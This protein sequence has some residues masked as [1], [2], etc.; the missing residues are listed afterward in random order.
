MSGLENQC[1]KCQSRK[2]Q[3]ELK[4]CG[5]CKS[6]LYCNAECQ[7]RDWPAHK[8]FCKAVTNNWHDKYRG[9]QDGSTHQGDLELITWSL[10]DD[11][12][13]ELGWGNIAIE[14]AEEHKH[15]FETKYGRDE[16]KFFKYWPRAFRWTCCGLAGDM[17]YGCDHHS[18]RYPKP[19]TCDFCIMGEPLPNKIFKEKNMERYGLNLPRGPDPRSYNPGRAAINKMA[20]TMMGLEL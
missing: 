6:A 8:K 11:H 9:C 12:G 5:R 3:K 7:T 13:D 17:N 4:R 1:F 15:R 2:L 20:R 18:V 14:E 10:V 19:C 16:E